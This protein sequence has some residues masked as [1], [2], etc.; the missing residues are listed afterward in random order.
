MRSCHPVK[1]L[2]NWRGSKV[3]L[4]VRHHVVLNRL[5]FLITPQPSCS[6]RIPLRRVTSCRNLNG[7]RWRDRRCGQDLIAHDRL[8]PF[9]R[10]PQYPLLIGNN[11]RYIVVMRFGQGRLSHQCAAQ[12]IGKRGSLKSPHIL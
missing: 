5:I 1:R 10:A 2:A 12:A 8:F 11:G 4:T 6:R 7:S 3:F 9:H